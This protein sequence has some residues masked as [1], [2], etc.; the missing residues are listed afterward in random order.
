MLNSSNPRP[1]LRRMFVGSHQLRPQVWCADDGSFM[2]L[3]PYETMVLGKSLHQQDS[4]G[5]VRKYQRCTR[6]VWRRLAS[7]LPDELLAPIRHVLLD[8]HGAAQVALVD[9]PKIAAA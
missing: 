1:V 4:D 2:R 7:R 8:I 5:V 9:P 6:E 3:L